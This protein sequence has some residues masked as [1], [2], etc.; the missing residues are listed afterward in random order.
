MTYEDLYKKY[1]NARLDDLVIVTV[2]NGYTEL[3]EKVCCDIIKSHPEYAEYVSAE[4]EKLMQ[5]KKEKHCSKVVGYYDK[6]A[7]DIAAYFNFLLIFPIAGIGLSCYVIAKVSMIAGFFSAIGILGVLVIL[8]IIKE[9]CVM[10][11]YSKARQYEQLD[12][13]KKELKKR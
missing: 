12:E 2:E 10:H 1:Q 8:L 5:E 6:K 7:S 4:N 3:A 13:L 11:A 9:M